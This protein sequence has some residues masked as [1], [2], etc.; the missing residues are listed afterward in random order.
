MRRILV[1]DDDRDILEIMKYILEDSGYE[2]DTLADGNLIFDKIN[3]KRP[4]LI[5]LD[6][7]LGNLD[8]RQLCKQLKVVRES[9][10]IPIIL[11]SASHT[12]SQCDDIEHPDD[13]IEKPFN[14]SRLLNSVQRQLAA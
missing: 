7:M 10:N 8:G 3:N 5:L 14:I 12:A 2:V 9:K 1:V 4:D 6:V 13:F 11:I